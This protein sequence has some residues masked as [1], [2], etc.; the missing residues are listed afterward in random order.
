MSL[1][2]L[3]YTPHGPWQAETDSRRASAMVTDALA[4]DQKNNG[5]S[6][7]VRLFC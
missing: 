7:A 6:E 4:E 1:S 5:Q 3:F 2:L